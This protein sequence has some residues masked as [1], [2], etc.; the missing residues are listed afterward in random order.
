MPKYMELNYREISCQKSVV[1]ADFVR[2]NQDYSFSVAYPTS[3]IPSCSY[4]RQ[5]LQYEDLQNGAGGNLPIDVSDFAPSENTPN[6][7]YNNVYCRLAGQEI[8]SIVNFA[9]QASI[10]KHRYSTSGA[11]LDKVKKS[12]S[13]IDSSYFNRRRTIDTEL[14]TAA[15]RLLPN[16]DSLGLNLKKNIQDILFQ[17]PI[18]VFDYNGDMPSGD[19]RI[20]LNPSAELL[21][22][23]QGGAAAR[24]CRVTVLD[25]KLYI[26]TV[27][28]TEPIP[29]DRFNFRF[30]EIQVNSKPL[31]QNQTYEFQVPSSTYA[32]AWWV[33]QD[34]AGVPNVLVPNPIS[35]AMFTSNGAIEQAM[36]SY[37]I[38]YSNQTKPSTRYA[39]AFSA[40]TNKMQLRY[41]TDLVEN[42]LIEN[43]GGAESLEDWMERGPYYM[44]SF[45]RDK[46]DKSTQVQLSTTFS[47]APVGTNVFLAA[48]YW[49]DV[50]V[51]TE[52]GR[53]QSVRS[54][55][56]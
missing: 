16:T 10:L 13:M 11:V 12:V 26:C 19:Y 28:V 18:A 54:L 41:F 29:R 25:V 9:P 53:T 23:A 4:F 45:I 42:N 17:P 52:M 3:W 46:D 27:T 22:A 43:P 35:L 1:G 44:H 33:Q 51:V 31:T 14:A 37:Q 34:T 36:T 56:V 38:T 20:S 50:E 47:D 7:M 49:K 40:N 39:T 2:G 6:N 48:L 24:N 30:G 21:F 8:S 32:L 15:L 5:T 55:N